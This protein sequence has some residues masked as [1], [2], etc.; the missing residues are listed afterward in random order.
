MVSIAFR[1]SPSA[2]LALSAQPESAADVLLE[3]LS[4]CRFGA[5]A[6]GANLHAANIKS[7]NQAAPVRIGLVCRLRV[8][9]RLRLLTEN[10]LHRLRSI[11]RPAEAA[12]QSELNSL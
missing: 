12:V 7:V 5:T 11:C 9:F 1:D 3:K 2:N 8:E 10:F 4:R 6:S